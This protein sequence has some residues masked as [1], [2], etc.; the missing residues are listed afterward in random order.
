LSG[1]I[2]KLAESYPHWFPLPFTVA[3]IVDI[4]TL[5]AQVKRLEGVVNLSS[6]AEEVLGLPLDKA[7]QISDWQRRPLSPPQLVYAA[8]D[9]VVLVE[10]Y[11][12]LVSRL[13]PGVVPHVDTT[14]LSEV[15]MIVAAVMD[16]ASYTIV[17]PHAPQVAQP[18][19]PPPDA[20]SPPPEDQQ[21]DDDFAASTD[22]IE[23]LT[24]DDFARAAKA[25]GVA[26]RIL[27]VPPAATAGE[28][29][30]A[31]GVPLSRIVKSIG[32][33]ADRTCPTPVSAQ[34]T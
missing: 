7:Q 6:V 32:V 13:D 11:D 8:L 17:T 3:P 26:D 29:A 22:V 2:R 4:S 20:V 30:A 24:A 5:Y 25:L 23:P 16:S 27:P 10:L 12:V 31:L 34:W 9:A 33:I 28:A 1:D 19:P 18:S 14:T 21:P 15:D